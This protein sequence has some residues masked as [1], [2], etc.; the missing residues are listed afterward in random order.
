[1]LLME[2]LVKVFLHL[3]LGNLH[4]EFAYNVT[5]SVESCLPHQDRFLNRTLSLTRHLL[6]ASLNELD[7]VEFFELVNL[8]VLRAI[9]IEIV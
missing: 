7:E 3:E 2:S 9:L 8:S 6:H 1:M 4:F 5:E